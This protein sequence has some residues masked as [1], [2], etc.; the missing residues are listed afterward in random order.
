MLTTVCV[1]AR[2]MLQ[3]MQLLDHFLVASP[4]VLWLLHFPRVAPGKIVGF[5]LC[6]A[7]GQ[8]SAFM[9]GPFSGR[10]FWFCTVH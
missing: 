2:W 5:D 1:G 9:G 4:H 7:G 10:L 8:N 6:T 3:L